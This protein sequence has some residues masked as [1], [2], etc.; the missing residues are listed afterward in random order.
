MSSKKSS[1]P[2]VLLVNRCIVLND[3][4]KILLIRRAKGDRWASGFWE[5]PGGKLDEGQDISHALEREVIEET[6]LL[7]IPSS[8]IAFVDSMI[9][10]SGPYQGM[11]YVVIVG[12]G[13]CVGGD[14]TLSS[15]HDAYRWVTVTQALSLKTKEEVKKSLVALAK[16]L[17]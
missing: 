13:K 9:I 6:G 16:Q 5:F 7:V 4:N 10:A 14:L 3:N 11:P 1:R 17:H 2:R 15:E 12:I 8:R